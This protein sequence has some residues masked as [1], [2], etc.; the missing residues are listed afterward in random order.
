MN[1]WKKIKLSSLCHRI[2]DGLHGTPKYSNGTGYFFINGNN[3]EN[4]KI[5]ITSET[6]EVSK[7]EYLKNYIELGENSLLLGING[8]LGNMAFFKGEHLMLGKSSAFINFKTDINK[9]YYYYFQLPGVQNYFY[10]VATGSTIKNLSLT[11]LKDFEVPVPEIFEYRKIASV[12]SALDDKIALNNRIN[13][14]LEQ[15]AKTLYDYWFVQFDFPVS[16]HCEE[17]GTSDV[18]ISKNAEIAALHDVPLAMTGYKSSGGKMLYNAQLKREIPEGWEVRNLFDICD[19]QYGFPFST[20]YFNDYKEGIPVIRIRDILENSISNYS[21]QSEVDEKYLINRG[22]VLVGMDGNFHINYWS[23]PDCYLN[24]RVVKFSET[25]LPSIYLKHQIEPFIKAREKSISRTT[26][27]HLSDKD[28][29]AIH[30]IIPPR[31]LLETTKKIFSSTLDK[32]ITNLQQNQSLASL[33]D[34]LLPMLMNG[35]VQVGEA[36]E[37]AGNA[38]RPSYGGQAAQ[39]DNLGM[40]AEEPE[41]YKKE[42]HG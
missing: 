16:R 27:G 40:V 42:E 11:S 30:I 3:L 28:L 29:K 41:E 12:L 10:Y 25:L 15:M 26:V 37:M 22:D 35:Q 20:D 13:A 2:G 24:Q 36:E 7:D 18:A 4:G 14:E 8:T 9:F 21:T 38:L 32:M 5:I 39:S 34:W 33:R 1:N 19:V 23:R 6:K 31:E 17:R